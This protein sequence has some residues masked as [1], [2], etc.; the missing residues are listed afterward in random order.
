MSN[1]TDDSSLAARLHSIR[2]SIYMYAGLTVFIVGT[3]G[4]VCNIILFTQLD[5]F[6]RLASSWFLVM[7]FFGSQLFLSTAVLSRLIVWCRLRWTLGP[8]GSGTALTFLSLASIDRYFV[9]SRQIHRHRWIT[10]ERTR[11]IIVLVVLAWL[12]AVIPNA[13]FYT[14]PSCTI[15]DAVYSLAST[16]FSVAAYS[17]VPSAVMIVSS[18]LTWFNLRHAHAR[19]R[20]RIRFQHQVNGM[21]LAQIAM[22]LFTAVPN[23]LTQV[24]IAATRHMAKSPARQGYEEVV[25]A[26]L[27][28]L[29]YV[30][31]AGTFYVYV[32]VSRGYRNKA[33]AIILGDQSRWNRVSPQTIYWRTPSRDPAFCV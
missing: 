21:M 17:V 11:C 9:T 30:T 1:S 22:V 23:A 29:G 32:I 14:S 6:T 24:Y 12:V 33:K 27:S 4:N 18:T 25:V 13:I 7:S 28:M 19:T 16:I 26:I 10:L 15:T 20:H 31:H 8:L 3:I 2:D 5:S